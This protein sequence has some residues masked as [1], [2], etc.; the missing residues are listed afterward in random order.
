MLKVPLLAISAVAVLAATMPAMA[1]RIGGNSG[2][3]IADPNE[4]I[5]G[6]RPIAGSRAYGPPVPYFQDLPPWDPDYKPPLDSDGHPDLQGVWSTASLTTMTRGGGGN[7]NL[8]INSLVIPPEKIAELTGKAHFTQN[9]INSQKRTDPNAGVFTDKDVAAGYN[10]FWSDPGSEWAKVN[11]EW[12]SSWITSPAN[13]QVPLSPQGR[14][15]RGERMAAVKSVDNTGPEIRAVGDRCLASFGSHAGPP[16]NNALYNNNY[17]IVQT[18]N[19]VL[20]DV[21]MNHDARIIA[22]TPKGEE[23][24]RPDVMKP[25]FG[26]SVG[27]WENDTL[28]VETRNFNPVQNQIGAY[29]VSPAGKVTEWFRRVSDDVIQ[30]KFE[31]NDPT[32][33]TQV[34]TGEIPL[35]RSKEHLFEYACHEGNYALPGILRGDAKGEDTAIEAQGE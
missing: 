17:Q 16:L 19:A 27:H 10:T 33:Y 35:R 26:D 11:T 30:Y 3:G 29:P 22:V 4:K 5:E 20:I 21:E 7:Q 15:L 1:Q 34:W 13:G 32:Y 31:V 24:Y 28:V 23:K 12:R 2:V 6:P 14:S 8:G 9:W 25:W 18:P